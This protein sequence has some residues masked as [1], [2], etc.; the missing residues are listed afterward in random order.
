MTAQFVVVEGPNGVG[1]TTVARLVAARLDGVDGHPSLLT[2]EPTRS[3]LGDLLRQEEWS[4]HGRA[5]ALA[6]AADR[7]DHVET[8]IIPA[9]DAGMH[10]VS[11]R[12]VQSS[13][14]LQRIDGLDLEEIWGYN[15]YVLQA[16]C[17]YL[18]DRP[19]VI[20]GRLAG[21]RALTRLELA[22][23]PQIELDYY[24]DARAFLA[25]PDHSWVQYSI[26]CSD[27]TPD[28]IA[29]E[30]LSLLAANTRMEG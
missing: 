3:P 5:F 26:D 15:Q 20:A 13:M 29:S 27:R 2:T 9:L 14:V 18:E 30:I 28:D 16:T 25:Q 23:N 21:R 6:L 4:L 19:E 1:K 10:V 22:G 17:F 8:V 7:A 11:D 12:Y 24:R